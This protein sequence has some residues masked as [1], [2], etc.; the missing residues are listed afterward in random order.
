MAFLGIAFGFYNIFSC[1]GW[2]AS[3]ASNLGPVAF[4]LGSPCS[5][6]KLGLVLLFLLVAVIRKWGGEEIDVPFSF[7]WALILGLGLYFLTITFT[8]S[9]KAAMLV[10]IIASLVGGYGSGYIMG[11]ENVGGDYQ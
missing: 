8:G 1:S 10:G 3:H 4:D 2:A 7:M 11:E 5:M 6:A 9:F